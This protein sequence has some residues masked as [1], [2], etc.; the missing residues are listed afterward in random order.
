MSA[1]RALGGIGSEDAIPALLEATK[2]R[3]EYV[4]V[5]AAEALGR[6]G[7]E[8]AIPALLEATKDRSEYVCR[9]AAKALHAVCIRRTS[10]IAADEVPMNL[11]RNLQSLADTLD[12]LADLCENR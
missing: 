10:P 6:I 1:A 11:R 4:R 12:Q 3:S 5:S 2:D 8:D 7:S 9:Q